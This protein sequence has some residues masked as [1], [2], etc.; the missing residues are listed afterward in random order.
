MYDH[1]GF[2]LVYGNIPSDNHTQD[3]SN[4]QNWQTKVG[5]LQVRDKNLNWQVYF[6]YI[7]NQGIFDKIIVTFAQSTHLAGNGIVEIKTKKTKD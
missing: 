1:A 4:L 7:P 5:H 2:T 3:I 6:S